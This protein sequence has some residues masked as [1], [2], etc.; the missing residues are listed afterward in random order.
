GHSTSFQRC[1]LDVWLRRGFRGCFAERWYTNR[2]RPANR[3]HPVIFEIIG[4]I[5]E[6]MVLI[7][8]AKN[9]L[10]LGTHYP[11]PRRRRPVRLAIKNAKMHPPLPAGP[12]PIRTAA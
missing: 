10:P 4:T 1:A 2:Y 12:A 5:F 6:V 11:R 8:R 9:T 3:A 7:T